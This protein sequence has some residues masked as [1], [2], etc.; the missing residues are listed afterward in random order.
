MA[1]RVLIADDHPVFRY[2]L[3]SVLANDE[4]IEVIAEAECA[5]ETLEKVRRLQPDVLVLDLRLP[6]PDG[7]DIATELRRGGCDTKILVLT[8]YDSEDF[9]LDA[10]RVGVDGYLLKSSSYNTVAASIRQVHNGHR[11]VCAEQ[12]EKVLAEFERLSRTVARN[13]TGLSPS[14]LEILRHLAQGQTYAQIGES[15]YLSEATVKRRIQSAIEKLDASSRTEAV[16][17]AI[18]EGLI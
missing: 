18:R 2:G 16:A 11:L 14:E 13:Q 9:L 6:G 17:K 10:L 4:A 12:M 7:I 1:I 8:A 5:A 3:R 15:V